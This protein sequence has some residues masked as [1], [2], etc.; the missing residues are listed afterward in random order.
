MTST[1][2]I[3]IALV[4]CDLNFTMFVL[5]HLVCKAL[6]AFDKTWFLSRFLLAVITFSK[7]RQG[8]RKMHQSI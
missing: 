6:C 1:S 5:F 2:H 3:P 7:S 4:I 8:L